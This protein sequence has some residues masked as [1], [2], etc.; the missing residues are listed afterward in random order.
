MNAY[1]KNNLSPFYTVFVYLIPA[2]LMILLPLFDENPLTWQFVFYIFSHNFIIGMASVLFA[3]FYS[4][5][6]ICLFREKY[7][8]ILILLFKYILLFFYT[9]ISC[10]IMTLWGGSISLYIIV[11]AYWLCLFSLLLFFFLEYN[12]IKYQ[13]HLCV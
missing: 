4:V 7:F 3:L 10:T 6:Q 11:V 12:Y 2:I 8:C 13:N 1:K 5:L 9:F